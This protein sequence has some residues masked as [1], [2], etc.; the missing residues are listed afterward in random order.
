[1]A[2]AHFSSHP[3]DTSPPDVTPLAPKQRFDRKDAAAMAGLVV[4]VV[5]LFWRV[6][7][8]SDMLYF[9][10]IFNYSYPHAKLI[11][12]I[13]RGGHLPYWNPLLNWGQPLLSNP[14]T[15][16]FYPY[17]LFIILLP[18]NIAYPLH[19]V[20]H[21]SIAALGT[22]VLARRWGQSTVAAFFA[23][24]FFAFSGPVLSL[25]NFYN[26]AACVAW[27]PWALFFTDSAIRKRSI[28]PWILLTIVFTLQF[29]AGE[30]M[31]LM[32]TFGLATVYALH[33]AGNLWRPWS[34]SSLRIL[35][36]FFLVGTVMVALAAVQ[37]L[38][39]LQL[40]SNSRR[41]DGLTFWQAGYWSFHPL[42]FLELI[43]PDFF[44][45]PLGDVVAWKLSLNS[46]AV[47]LLLSYFLGFIPVFLALAGWAMGRDRRRNFAAGGVTVLFLLA[48]GR[49]TPLYEF[50]FWAFPPL[51]LVRFPV[52][53]LLPAVLLTA[54]LAGWG[55]DSLRHFAEA[56]G[57]KAKLRVPLF[58]V[59]AGSLLVWA[60]AFLHPQWIAAPARWI[61]A[62]A[63][64]TFTV[65]PE[66]PLT[67]AEIRQSVEYFLT[68]VRI[69]FPGLIGYSLGAL[70]WLMALERRRK[71][72][73]RATA[74]IACA[75]VATLVYINYSIN[76][77]AP[78]GF[79]DYRP[80]VL[81]H[82]E[83][84]SPPYRFCDIVH[85]RTAAHQAPALAEFVNFDSVPETSGFSK[86]LL[87]TF[88][89]KILLS[90]GTMLTGLESATSSDV[91]AS[92]SEPYYVFW[93]FEKTQATD[94]ARY[95]CLLGR[96]NVKYLIS[97]TR[98]ESAETREIAEIFNGSPAPSYL[99][100][101]LCAAP[102][103]YAAGAAL[104]SNSARETLKKL[105]D[106]G[107]DAA[108]SVVLPSGT[109]TAIGA[110]E[111]G[112]AGNVEITE[113]RASAMSLRANLTRPG[114]VVL[115]DRYDPNWH[116][117]LDGKEVPILP[118][119]VLF[120]AV[121]CPAGRHEI[122]F[123]FR[124]KG[125]AIGVAISFV[126]LILL[127]LLYWRNPKLPSLKEQR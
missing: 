72:A 20:V 54:L 71:W 101:D 50:L 5:G 49:F 38:P 92:V 111:S 99:Y 37:F 6:L 88:R 44:G 78:K 95:A 103:A 80:P 107:F 68:M 104:F 108:G 57:S 64:R 122:R 35:A 89:E 110:G 84:S 52:K 119:N 125:L 87:S 115:L 7:F 58:I 13:C 12:D 32:A 3:A 15:L 67:A 47:P 31:T 16:F 123:H 21:I 62:S 79:Y 91:D 94:T 42:L 2:D 51:R 96:A 93:A 46:G 56:K 63:N 77:V 14:N 118:A 8:T 17:T 24:A 70:A 9:R 86:T 18:I 127:S 69:H 121:E 48:L 22:Y 66:E 105:S 76:P 85:D 90:S 4:I 43:L 74:W 41:G 33:R 23:G 100:Q 28:R 10:D 60:L 25:G 39:S 98:E 40:L 1:M 117:T 29:L 61:L 55:V 75:G 19:Y 83:D 126:T 114:Y 124:Q 102:R 30:P 34:R 106:P 109:R 73:Q 11:H 116:A 53:L 59:L 120:R 26:M 36:C 97:R 112:P 27:M 65:A 113:R 81:A 82:M 45:P